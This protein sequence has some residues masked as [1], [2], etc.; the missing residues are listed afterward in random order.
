MRRKKYVS[1]QELLEVRY[2]WGSVD[3][4]FGSRSGSTPVKDTSCRI[5]M[6]EGS[7]QSWSETADVES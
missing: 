7:V 3:S 1:A 5:S 6:V 4:V 2:G